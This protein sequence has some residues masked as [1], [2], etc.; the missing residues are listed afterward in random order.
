MESDI[1]VV[2]YVIY[3]PPVVFILFAFLQA[4]CKLSELDS[5][6]ISKEY[7][8]PTDAFVVGDVVRGNGIVLLLLF[9]GLTHSF[10]YSHIRAITYSLR[11][12][13]VCHSAVFWIRFC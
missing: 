2:L 1:A 8:D 7:K 12:K 11:F 5:S 3:V 10:D 13:Q 4:F 6:E 9:K